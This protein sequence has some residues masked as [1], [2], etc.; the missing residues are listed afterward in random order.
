MKVNEESQRKKLRKAMHKAVLVDFQKINRL[1][2][3][4][5]RLFLSTVNKSNLK[6]IYV[7]LGK[8]RITQKDLYWFTLTPRATNSP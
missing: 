1:F 7:R 3:R 2:L 5:N 6:Q 8:E 4:L